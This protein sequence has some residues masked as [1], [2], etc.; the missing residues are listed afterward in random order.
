[1]A[2]SRLI[3]DSPPLVDPHSLPKS[4]DFSLLLEVEIEQTAEASSKGGTDAFEEEETWNKYEITV[5]FKL[6]FKLKATR[7]KI[8]RVR[9][10]AGK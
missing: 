3:V 2:I 6:K 5:N 9:M 1:M 7:R 4:V 10:F 8:N